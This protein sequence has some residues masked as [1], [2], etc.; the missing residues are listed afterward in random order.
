KQQ[1]NY[2]LSVSYQEQKRNIES[3]TRRLITGEK[4]NSNRY[5]YNTR[6]GM[7]SRGSLNQILNS[8]RYNFEIVY[9]V[10]LDKG[11]GSGLS[12]QNA[13]ENTQSNRLNSYSAFTSAELNFTD[14]LSFRPG[15]R[16]INSNKFSDQFAVS[17]SGKY[18]FNNDFQLR[19]IAGTS[20]KIPNFEQL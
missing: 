14:R 17:L 15:F 6:E 9:E 12:D 16:Y 13:S 10:D 2:D 11:T 1:M 5:D 7:Y 8:N 19:V 4:Y 18:Q 20:P 3:F